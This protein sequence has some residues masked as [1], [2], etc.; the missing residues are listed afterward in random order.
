VN[1]NIKITSVN[2][3]AEEKWAKELERQSRQAEVLEKY[4][5]KASRA[6]SP[7]EA[8]A[9]KAWLEFMKEHGL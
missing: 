4:L 6:L 1:F 9:E 2:E 3:T 5:A 8:L 7:E